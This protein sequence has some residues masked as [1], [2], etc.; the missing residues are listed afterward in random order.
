[1]P[2]TESSGFSRVCP[3][4]GR[5]VPRKVAVCRCGAEIGDDQNPL[6]TPRPPDQP[7]RSSVSGPALLIGVAL[8]TVGLGAFWLNRPGPSPAPRTAAPAPARTI[9]PGD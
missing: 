9:D 2:D 3:F 7:A 6:E 4:C 8:V 1:M 5:R